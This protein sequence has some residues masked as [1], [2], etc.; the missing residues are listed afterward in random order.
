MGELARCAEAVAL[1][2][3]HRSIEPV[4]VSKVKYDREIRKVLTS[5][6]RLYTKLIRTTYASEAARGE[7]ARV[8]R[9]HIVPV[10]VLVDRMIMA[11]EGARE[12]LDAVVLAQITPE[13]HRQLGGIWK[14]H[15]DLYGVMLS[16]PLAELVE[17]GLKRYVRSGVEVHRM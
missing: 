11:P 14:H 16:C 13:E 17:L 15:E 5:V 10:R 7:G 8:H 4:H 6:V 9:D 3:E 12:I 1:I 2:A